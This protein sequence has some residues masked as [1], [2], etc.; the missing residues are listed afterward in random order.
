MKLQNETITILSI[1]Y[2]SNELNDK[3]SESW[4]KLS[5]VLTHEIMNTIYQNCK[6]AAARNG[7]GYNL[8]AGANIAGFERV[9]DAMLAQGVF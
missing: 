2:I 7:L 3:E 4:N 6:D 9:A 8:V 1:K 5:H